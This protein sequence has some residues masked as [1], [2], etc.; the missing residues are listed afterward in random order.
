M[1][2]DGKSVKAGTKIPI[3]TVV[4]LVLGAGIAVTEVPIPD[5]FGMRLADA[6]VVLEAN[7]VQMGSVVLD[8]DVSQSDTA[9][10]FIYRQNPS[11]A[12]V[13]GMPNLIHFGQAIDVYIGKQIPVRPD[14][15][16][17]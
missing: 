12:A 4:S 7:G 1:L 3:G 14:T 5:L 8:G 13:D 17:P 11:P 10:A 9:A 2:V 15:T 6:R 16:K